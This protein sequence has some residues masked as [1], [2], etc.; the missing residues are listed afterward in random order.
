MVVEYGVTE[1]GFC[2]KTYPEVLADMQARARDL[3]GNEV[4]LEDDSPLGKFIKLNAFETAI[5]WNEAENVYNSA[6][7]FSASG[8]Q[9]DNIVVRVGITR[10]EAT[11]AQ[12]KV[13]FFGDEGIEI[14]TGFLIETDTEDSI[15]FKTTQA[16]IIDSSGSIMLD[17]VA[18]EK[19]QH[20]NVPADTI[21]TITN[22]LPGL[23]RVTNNKKTKGGQDRESDMELRDRYFDSV[24]KAGGSTTN[25]ILANVF[26][27]DG[28]RAAIVI[29]NDTF[30]EVD[31]IPPKSFETVVLGGIGKDIANAI[32]DKKAGGIQAYGT[33][34]T[35]IL[36]DNSGEDKIIKF[37]RA[38]EVPVY[39]YVSLTTNDSEFPSDGEIQVKNEIIDYIGGTNSDGEKLLGLSLGDDVVYNKII[40]AVMS[41]DGVQD[42]SIKIGKTSSPSGTSNLTFNTRE[43]ARIDTDKVVVSI[44]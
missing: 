41:V 22:P 1:Q 24:S 25:A 39:V 21:T 17:I 19:G 42:A 10:K 14:P 27:V 32:M 36:Q 35:Y 9:L 11:A 7:V 5:A 4:N 15:Q 38:V 2:K 31:G 8:Q 13:I 18:K 3:F 33:N 30:Q 43:V 6:Y 40:D 23:D 28:V 37:S 16:G 20:T 44:V 29:E 26:E 34:E 12:G